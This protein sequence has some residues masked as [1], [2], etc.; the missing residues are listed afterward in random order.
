MIRVVNRHHITFDWKMSDQYV[1]IGRGTI[2]GNPFEINDTRARTQSLTQFRSYFEERLY[3]DKCFLEE[4]KK[5]DNKI[6]V[7]SCSPLKCHGDII[8]EYVRK[9]CQ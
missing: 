1:Y 6:L 5:L 9:L 4:V 8:A 7:C 3:A 2:Y